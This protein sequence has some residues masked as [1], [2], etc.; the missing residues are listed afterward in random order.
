MN[1][2]LRSAFAAL[3]TE[4]PAT[5]PFARQREQTTPQSRLE[6]RIRNEFGSEPALSHGRVDDP[7]TARRSFNLRWLGA[8]VLVGLAGVG[9]LGSAIYVSSEGEITFAEPAEQMPD[10]PRPEGANL[11]ARKG[12]KLVRS[13]VTA[14]AKQTFRAPTTIRTGDREVIRL[15]SFVRLSANLSLTSG[16]YSAGIPPFNPMRFF[17]D[18][19]IVERAADS[20][21]DPGEAEVS[22][23]KSDLATL[24]IPPGAP[25]LGD[26]AVAA[27]LADEARL[28]A[29]NGRRVGTALPPAPMLSR[30]LGVLDASGPAAAGTG[31]LR[32]A[33]NAP[34]RSLDVRVEDENV[35]NVAK[36]AP[37]VPEFSFEERAV[38]LPRIDG[39]DGVLR[40]NGASPE[41]ARAMTAAIGSRDRTGAPEAQQLRLLIGPAARPGAARQIMRAIL[42]SERGIEAIAALNDR[43]SYVSVTPPAAE[44]ARSAS[45][46]PSTN[47]EDD[48]EEG[49]GVPLYD[50]LYETA[51]KHDIPRQTVEDLIRIFGYDVDFQ[52]RVGPGDTIELFCAADDE[53]SDRLDVLM[54]SITLG[55]ETH[56]VYRYQADDGSVDYFDDGGRSLKKFLIRKP[57]VEARLSSGFGSRFHPILGYAKM[58][59]GVDWAAPSGTPILA[60]GNGTVIHADWSSGYGKRTEVQHANGYVTAYN[61][62]SAFA[63]GIVPG[64]KVRQG[65]VIGFVGT[66]GLSTGAHLHFE[67]LI[68]GRFVDPMKIRVPR[69][70]ELD[71]RALVEFNRQR[72]ETDGILEK[73]GGT[74]RLAQRG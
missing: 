20:G 57:V 67:V 59:T 64:A 2:P 27:Q 49:S 62:Q 8:S 13:E 74:S 28:S 38:P 70:R 10:G 48:E 30:M 71:G 15:R 42:I 69:G 22:V 32:P 68:N 24:A 54:A 18:S 56:R 61:H 43:G 36:S 41:D 63:R 60:A 29:E 1:A 19:G 23:V 25:A 14:A 21:A 6:R 44:A 51:L 40:G 26:D 50:S 46:K 7:D 55:S 5:R 52:R 47:G 12:D 17:T 4:T 73:A 53:G 9:L 66:T 16:Q 39:L 58:H 37:R 33:V 34:F 35:V 45:A 65:Q 72:R 11:A 3:A 31:L